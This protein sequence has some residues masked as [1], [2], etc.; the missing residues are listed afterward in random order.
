MIPSKGEVIVDGKSL[1]KTPKALWSKVVGMMPQHYD[2]HIALSVFDSILLALKSHG[3]WRVNE[4]D[5][6]LVERVLDT[7]N[8]NHLSEKQIYE[9]S[10][11][12]KQMV[13]MARILV[14]KPP[15][16]LLDEPTSALDLN[17]QLSSMTTIK[18][19]TQQQGLRSIIALHD[20][21]LAAAFCDRLLLI[22]QGHLLLDGKPKEV[23]S[24]PLV[25]ET[26]NVNINLENTSR[27][28]Y[29]VDAF[30]D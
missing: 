28:T 1:H 18:K 19:V 2:V 12:Q 21:N 17:Y 30:L 23:L 16:I 5:L 9:L 26:Y 7:L 24:N 20:L 13:A 22:K 4:N 29:F 3:G 6:K 27:N 11:G 8:L 25:K 14:R 15:L 10:G